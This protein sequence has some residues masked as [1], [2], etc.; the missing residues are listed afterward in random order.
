MRHKAVLEGEWWVLYIDGERIGPVEKAKKEDLT[1]WDPNTS[2]DTEKK[3][4]SGQ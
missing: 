2:P 4:G 1:S 3:D